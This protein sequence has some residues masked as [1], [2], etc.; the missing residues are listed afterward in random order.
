MWTPFLIWGPG[1]KKGYV[2]KDPISHVDQL[3]T[4]YK[5]M[6]VKIPKHVQG[7]VLEEAFE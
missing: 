1:I 5:M 3:P 2:F 4:I 7:R 6:G